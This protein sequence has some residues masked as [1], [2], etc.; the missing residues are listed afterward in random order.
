MQQPRQVGPSN[1]VWAD[2]AHGLRDGDV[3]RALQ[4]LLPEE[5]AA[6]SVDG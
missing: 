1:F 3:A 4:V 5:P 6:A 2:P